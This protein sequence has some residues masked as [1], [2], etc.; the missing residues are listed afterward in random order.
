MEPQVQYTKTSDGVNIAYYAIGQGPA[1]LLLMLPGSHLEAEWQIDPLRLGY[2]AWAQR[3]TLVRLDPRGFGLS[4]RDPDDFAVD[5]LV[6]DIEAVVDRLGLDQL[7]IFSLGITTVPALAYTARHPDKVTHLVQARA[8]ASGRDMVNERLQKLVELGKIDWELAS[9]T[10][11]RT[12]NPDFP[13]QLARDFAGLLRAAIEPSS[14]E[15]FV[16]DTRQW[17]VEA[18][19]TSLSTPTLLIHE[20][21]NP[22]FSMAATRRVAGLIKHSRVAFVDTAL[23]GALVAQRFFDGAVPDLT[24]PASTHAD[25]SPEAG[26]THTILFTDM[27][28][29]TALTQRL[30][31]ATAQEIRRTHNEIV[32]SALTANGGSEIKHTGDGIMASFTTA[33]AALECA[34]A[35]QRGVAA[36]VE[37]HPDSPLGLYIGLNA[38]EPIAE[39]GDLFGTSINL[40]ARICDHAEPGQIL[41][42]NVVRELAAGKD[43]LFADLGETELRGFEDPV[44]LWEVRWREQ[45]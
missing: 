14:F 27:Q 34:I 11:T 36:H 38:G 29:S 16:E 12:L 9:E 15:R 40:A 28:S 20:R 1:Q 32:R 8:V 4:D 24:E 33:S 39:E 26:V 23:E 35:I 21:N 2:I 18:D 43:F 6:L 10:V 5:S 17:D 42:A 44:K 7:R 45:G 19:A 25:T 22:N 31:D 37:E 41:A 13:E 3:S 30:G